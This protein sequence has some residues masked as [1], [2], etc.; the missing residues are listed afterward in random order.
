MPELDLS[1]ID[2]N[3][4][5]PTLERGGATRLEL[6]ERTGPI[7]RTVDD[8]R[9][10]VRA[11]AAVLRRRGLAPRARVAIWGRTSYAWIVIDLACLANGYLTVPLDPEAAWDHAS[12]AARFALELVITDRSDATGDGFASF[13]AI[14]G[15]SLNDAVASAALEAARFAEAEPF[16]VVF[17]SGTSGEPRAIEVRKRCFDDQFSNALRMFALTAEDRMLV[18]LPMHIYLERCYVYLAILRGFSI[19]VA[20]PRFVVKALKTAG[21]TFTVGVPHFFYNLQDMFL[22]SLRT[23]RGLRVRYR[24]RRW[25]DRLG[26]APRRP[27]APFAAMLGGRARFLITGSAPC[28]RSALRFFRAMGIPLYEGY[29]M[30]EIAGMVALNCPGQMKIGTV[31]KVF[32]NKEVKLDDGGQI[33]VRGANAANTG[34][35]RASAEDNAATFLSDGWVATG[36]VGHFDRDGYLTIDGRI[37]DVIVMSNGR[38]VQPGPLEARIDELDA[39]DRSIVVGDERPCLMA[40]VSASAG[41]DHAA[42][43]ERLKRLELEIVKFRIVDDPFSV[44]NGALNRAFKLDRAKIKARY[45]AQIDELY[46]A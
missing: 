26:V 17:T 5:I 10:D 41:A 38:K 19:V 2:L 15:G 34:Y 12:L 32:P 21:F 43:L 30:S 3:H 39:V 9:A 44:D 7:V 42:L 4:V 20:P 23:N 28:R 24:L 18:F 29:G 46:G 11:A 37:K 6:Y 35:W 31:G 22:L 33:L 1:T 8:L 16:T 14:C 13:D 36:D 45:A 40:L 27:F 25:L